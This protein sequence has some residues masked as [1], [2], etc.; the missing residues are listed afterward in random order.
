MAM[1]DKK[2][3]TTEELLGLLKDRCK[4]YL[5]EITHNVPVSDDVYVDPYKELA[6]VG[7]LVIKL[8]LYEMKLK[9]QNGPVIDITP[10][11]A[12]PSI[13]ATNGDSPTYRMGE[14]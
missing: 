6:A 9:E 11:P 1:I 5:S 13:N 3:T 8:A 12:L 7:G 10:F 2:E 14:P 4:D